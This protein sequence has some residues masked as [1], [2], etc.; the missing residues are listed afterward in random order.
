MSIQLGIVEIRNIIK[1][2]K[3]NYRYDFA[4]Y[5]LAS[6]KRRLEKFIVDNHMSSSQEFISNISDNKTYF[7]NFLY[8]IS[9]SETEMFRD[10]SF[11]VALRDIIIPQISKNKELNIWI[12]GATSGEE[13]YSLCILLNEN[14][15]LKKANITITALCQKNIDFIQAGIYEMKKTEVNTS[16]YERFGGKF[17]LKEY[18]KVHNNRVYMDTSLIEKA[19]FRVMDIAR[20][21]PDKKFNFVLFR[22]RM[23]YYN[24]YLQ[25]TVLKNIDEC[26]EKDGYLALG[27]KESIDEVLLNASFILY[28]KDEK[29]LK[30]I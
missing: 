15:F 27:I 9:V 25:N 2:I 30:K 22:N 26:I 6:F 28:D 4:N 17:D 1:T 3:D 20:E 24:R 14:Y 18:F 19:D 11:W 5:S 21:R 13:A 29:I 10:P 12:P 7:L 23:I 16:N 8:Q